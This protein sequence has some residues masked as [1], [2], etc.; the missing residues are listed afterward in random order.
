[1]LNAGPHLSRIGATMNIDRH[2]QGWRREGAGT[3]VGLAAL[4]Q[5]RP[6][7]RDFIRILQIRADV[8]G[9]VGG[10]TDLKAVARGHRPLTVQGQGKTI[11]HRR[12]RGIGVERAHGFAVGTR[13][14]VV[15]AAGERNFIVVGSQLA[16]IADAHIQVTGARTVTR[17]AHAT[18]RN[19]SGA[20]DVREQRRTKVAIQVNALTQLAVDR[21]R[22]NNCDTPQVIDGR[23]Q[24]IAAITQQAANTAAAEYIAQIHRGPTARIELD[25]VLARVA[26]TRHC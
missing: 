6:G 14:G 5:Q 22:S 18:L 3:L 15:V 13:D 9:A 10:R 1:M 12:R 26:R 24:D 4:T 11:N 23:H 19:G 2:R 16:G 17:R 20:V 8:G 7:E 25:G 21:V